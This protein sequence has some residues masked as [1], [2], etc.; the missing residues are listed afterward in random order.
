MLALKMKIFFCF[1]YSLVCKC[2]WSAIHLHQLLR[3]IQKLW[4]E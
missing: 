3:G 1:N 2:T 4:K